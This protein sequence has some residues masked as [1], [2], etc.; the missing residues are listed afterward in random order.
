MEREDEGDEGA[1]SFAR[2][3]E[4]VAD[5]DAQRALSDELH[6]LCTRLREEAQ[7]RG[8]DV[9]GELTLTLKLKV[10]P[11]DVVGVS[12]EI[13]SKLPGPRRS[14][15]VMWLTKGGNLTPSNPR[16]QRLP[17]KE[18]GGA[19]REVRDVAQTTTVKEL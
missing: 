17:L 1:R 2:L 7:A 3:I 14:K 18:V 5:G 4:Q 12:Y 16:Q 8:T 10:E 19:E 13:K 6:A 9:G 11:S 15:G